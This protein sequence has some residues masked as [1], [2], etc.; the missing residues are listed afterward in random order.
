MNYENLQAAMK[1]V[2]RA[3][4]NE[5]ITGAILQQTLSAIIDSLGTGYQF[6]GM[7]LPSTQPGTPDQR[8]FY[9]AATAGTYTGFGNT[10][11]SESQIG[12]FIYGATWTYTVINLPSGGVE[13]PQLD[14]NIEMNG[15]VV[16]GAVI[17]D[18][19]EVQGVIRQ[20]LAGGV[21]LLKVALNVHD[22]EGTSETTF[23]VA[24]LDSTSVDSDYAIYKFS[25]FGYNFTYKCYDDHADQSKLTY[26]KIAPA[27]PAE[28][29]ALKQRIVT[30]RR[31]DVEDNVIPPSVDVDALAS[32]IGIYTDI[33]SGSRFEFLKRIDI[34]PVQDDFYKYIAKRFSEITGEGLGLIYGIFGYIFLDF[35]A[36]EIGTMTVYVCAT[37]GEKNYIVNVEI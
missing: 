32:A 29:T 28:L 10:T 23:I 20:V 30:I 21:P 4:G 18:E 26:E 14:V 17:D 5:E 34:F 33:D 9:L 1:A 11:I 24:T 6:A 3:N 19:T 15:A 2:I 25:A 8:V 16:T 13:F 31:S 7:A 12:V 22:E 37:G 36:G 27:V 35:A